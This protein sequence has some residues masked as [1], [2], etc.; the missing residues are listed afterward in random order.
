[1]YVDAKI[2]SPSNMKMLTIPT[3]ALLDTGIR[4]VVYIATGDGRYEGRN[5]ITKP[6][7]GDYY[8]LVSGVKENENIVTYGAYLIDSQAE[9]SG[10]A[11][12]QYSSSLEKDDDSSRKAK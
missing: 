10:N 11:S 7:V 1:M 8:P 2:K 4:K 9:L 3:T 5:V 12:I 6:R